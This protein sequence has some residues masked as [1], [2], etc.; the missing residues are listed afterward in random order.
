MSQKKD[1]SEDLRSVA[2]CPPVMQKKKKQR[3]IRGYSD[4]NDYLCGRKQE[5]KNAA[6][7]VQETKQK[8]GQCAVQKQKRGRGIGVDQL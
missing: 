2:F 3:P 4:W 5:Q 1:E 7:Q 6:S 8:T